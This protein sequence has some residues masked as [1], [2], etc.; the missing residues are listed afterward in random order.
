VIVWALGVTVADTLSKWWARDALATKAHHLLGPLWLRL[1][2]NSGISFSINS[3]DPVVTTLLTLA[4][5]LIVMFVA[6]QAARGLATI[7]FGLL[8]GGGVSNE[9]DRLVR[10]P[11]QVT[12]FISVGRFPVFNLADAAVT[13]GFGVLLVALLRGST[14][15]KR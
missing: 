12:D 3:S 6:A 9:I 10:V 1:T 15:V 7:G 5:V 4:I 8:L 14:L 13:L 11:H 2:Y